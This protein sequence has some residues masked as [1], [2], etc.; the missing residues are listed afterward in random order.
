MDFIGDNTWCNDSWIPA[1]TG[2]HNYTIYM[3]DNFNHWN[4]TDGEIYVQDTTSPTHSN[5][6]ESAPI[7]ELGDPETISI[8]AFDLSGI[9]QLK[10][11]INDLNNYTM[12]F[13]GD[14]TWCND[15]WIPT[16]TGQ[17][18]YTIYMQDKNNNWNSTDGEIY[19][20]DTTLPTCL[21]I[22]ESAQILE[23]G[24]TETILVE[25]FD[26][27]GIKQVLL[28]INE[29]NNYSMDFIGD[30]TWR[31]DS[32]IPTFTGKHN[33][34]IYMQDKCNNWNST[35]GWIYVVIS[36]SSP[37]DGGDGGG[38]GGSGSSSS[39]GGESDILPMILVI[40]GGAAGALVGIIIFIKKRSTEPRDKELETIESII[41]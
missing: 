18:N 12:E 4:S 20:Q 24:N 40:V 34:T 31:N 38:G 2:Q 21:Y 10:I 32:W 3:E 28:E 14:N 8:K 37:P 36:D 6:E 27:S 9:N 7:L 5:L 29:L 17:H 26:L 1:F 33:Y 23:L 11:E 35:R 15:S 13:I 16:F 19:V 39:S 22:F 30:N 25:V 41:D